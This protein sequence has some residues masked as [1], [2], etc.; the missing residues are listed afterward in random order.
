M[1][2]INFPGLY[3]LT[4]RDMEQEIFP[5]CKQL[6]LGT[7]PW[8]ALAQGKLGGN[9]TRENPNA[10]NRASVVMT[11]NDFKIQDEVVAIAKEVGKTPSQVALNWTT[12]KATSPLLGCRTLAQLE[13]SLQALDFELT[14][15]QVARL[16]EVSK[17][18]PKLLFPHNFIGKDTKSS[19]FLY[20]PEK[21]YEIDN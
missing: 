5:M 7:V 17:E 21:K 13:D 10:G 15:Q 11:E 3:N 14:P 19:W 12:L 16:D 9:R 2:K 4:Q 20:L 1:G 18:S 8:S 6:R